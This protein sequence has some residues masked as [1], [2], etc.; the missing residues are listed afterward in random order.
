MTTFFGYGVLV[1]F[2]HL[3]D[4]FGVLTGQSRYLAT[5]PPKGYAP[6]LKSWENFY[7]R[8]LYHRIQDCWHRPVCSSPGAKIDIVQRS[9]KDGNK[10]LAPSG[11]VDKAFLNLGSY[12][13]LGFA[14]DWVNTCSKDVLHKSIKYN[15]TLWCLSLGTLRTS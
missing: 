5:I 11:G 15:V 12:N 8:R 2:G 6:L 7:T 4:F 13:Y 1:A 10:T 3:R 14:D 9:S